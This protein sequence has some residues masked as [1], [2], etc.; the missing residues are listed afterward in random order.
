M[1]LLPIESTSLTSNLCKIKIAPPTVSTSINGNNL[2]I[3]RKRKMIIIKIIGMV[4]LGF[5]C[6]LYYYNQ[7]LIEI[8]KITTKNT[9]SSFTS[10]AAGAMKVVASNNNNDVNKNHSGEIIPL[11]EHDQVK[12]LTNTYEFLHDDSIPIE[13]WS[14]H[15]QRGVLYMIVFNEDLNLARETI[16]YI[17]EQFNY[18]YQYPWILLNPHYFSL[19]FKKYVQK[20]ISPSTPVYFGKLDS[21]AWN[22]PDWIDVSLAEKSMMDLYQVFKGNSLSYHQLLRYHTGLFFHHPLFRNVEYTWRIDPGSQYP[23]D[24]SDIDPFHI[25]KKER[26]KLGFTIAMQDETDAVK[27]LWTTTKAFVKKY[28]QYIKSTKNSIM[29][30]IM[31]EEDD[32]IE[33]S[34]YNHCH[35]W[36]SFEIVDLSFLRSKEFQ[37]YFDYLDK[38]GGFFYEKWGDSIHTIA[39]AMF[40]DKKQIH[41]FD[42][43][44]YSK[45]DISHCPINPVS[46][47]KCTCDTKVYQELLDDSCTMSILKTISPI[48]FNRLIDIAKTDLYN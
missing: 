33:D 3:N 20:V 29:P 41:F 39:A 40:L 9:S 37:L 7:E 2:F 30:W 14:K 12:Q 36:S 5:I 13:V 22:Y 6:Y 32:R 11:V 21:Q 10:A 46:F 25:M 48:S 16:K 28:P 44:G 15:S 24:M 19:D 45:S 27:S 43:I 1:S 38:S 47:D 18:Q 35:L 26:K 4:L 34:Y 17:E 31:I 42:H 8:I 23:C